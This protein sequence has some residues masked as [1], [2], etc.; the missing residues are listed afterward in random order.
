[1][2][3]EGGPREKAPG[4]VDPR[5]GATTRV[6]LLLTL[7]VV[8]TAAS[9]SWFLL[10]SLRERLLR[11]ESIELRRQ[12]AVPANLFRDRILELER[13]VLVIAGTPPI[14]GIAR[15]EAN[16]GIDPLDGS[17][18]EEWR[19]RFETICRQLLEYKPYYVQARFIGVGD[20]G[21]E[22]VRVD[23]PLPD[24]PVRIVSH[25]DL[26]TKEHRDYFRAAVQRGPGE[27]HLSRI[28][29][30]REHRAIEAPPLPTIRAAVPAYFQD[31][32]HGIVVINL[33]VSRLFAEMAAQLD[34][35]REMLL[36]DE[37]GRYVWHPD[38]GRIFVFES[39]DTTTARSEYPELL[40]QLDGSR[41]RP[42]V[43]A[44][45]GDFVCVRGVEYGPADAPRRLGMI[46][47]RPVR[48]VVA[49]EG[50]VMRQTLAVVVGFV[51]F[52]LLVG[53]WFAR[54]ITEPVVR[55]TRELAARNQELA[56]FAYA[57]SHDLREPL[58]TVTSYAQVLEERAG[59]RLDGVARDAVGFMREACTRMQTRVDGLLEHSRIGV[60][61]TS[62]VVDF[63]ALLRE[64]LTDLEKS[65]SD[66]GARVEVGEMPTLRAY[67]VECRILFQ[68]LIENALKFRR[69]D[70]ALRVRI[71]STP[72][73]GGAIFVVEDNGIGIEPAYRERVFGIFERL[74]RQ[75]DYEGAGMGL[76][77]ARKV[78]EMHAG[79][80]AVED[81]IDGGSRFVLTLKELPR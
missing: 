15:A 4:N 37:F 34:R 30:N 53:A 43:E 49:L 10:S 33:V 50:Q 28:D 58:R 67:P 75:S 55:L 48:E 63:G 68:N 11:T 8:A 61:A 70:R 69:A 45:D 13:D 32:V 29:L 21:R 38:P 81:G 9:T 54:S 72:F 2:A 65:V 3:T 64:V 14:E 73:R 31:R 40:A 59:D 47:R 74:H 79:T 19:A 52:A 78:V 41:N 6:F 17:T 46:V 60:A 5:I 66:A 56:R 18:R 76:A 7:L 1:M 25:A 27:V 35:P 44:A 62:E 16:G 26:Q 51:F 24:A 42:H 57:A 23:R 22:I 80:I 71:S 20:R 77:H 12:T 39:G 36:T